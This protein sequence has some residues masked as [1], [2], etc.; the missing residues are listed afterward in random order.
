PG[1]SEDCGCRWYNLGELEEIDKQTQDVRAGKNPVKFVNT[2]WT[3]SAAIM[4]LR[5]L[6]SGVKCVPAL[7]WR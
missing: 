3:I 1:W 7:F 2:L 5:I 4:A 6:F